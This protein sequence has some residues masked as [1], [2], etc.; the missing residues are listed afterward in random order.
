[1]SEETAVAPESPPEETPVEETQESVTPESLPEET[2]VTEE[3][4]PPKDEEGSESS[5]E[6]ELEAIKKALVK[7]PKIHP[8]PKS[9]L[10]K[11]LLKRLNRNR[12]QRK[13]WI[14]QTCIKNR[15]D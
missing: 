8:S 13:N 14:S 6:T 15:K 9:R 5:P 4:Q 12:R 1:M 11:F 10:K 3:S 2:S 7:A